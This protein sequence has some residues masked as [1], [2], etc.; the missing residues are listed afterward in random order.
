MYHNQQGLIKD[1]NTLTNMMD[2]FGQQ[3]E[4]G[5]CKDHCG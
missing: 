1:P 2:S 3:Y 4:F 5:G